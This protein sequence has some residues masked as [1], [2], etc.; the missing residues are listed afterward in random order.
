MFAMSVRECIWTHESDDEI[1]TGG[2]TCGAAAVLAIDPGM[3]RS[4]S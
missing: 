1:E 2:F 3:R 4:S